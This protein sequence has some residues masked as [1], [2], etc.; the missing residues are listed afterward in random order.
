M[1]FIA[2]F[3]EPLHKPWQRIGIRVFGSWIAAS[4][5]LVLA[6]AARRLS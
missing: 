1:L 6:L 4:A 3:G 5:L 2:G